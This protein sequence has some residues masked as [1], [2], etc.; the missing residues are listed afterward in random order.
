M[1]DTA[2]L[3]GIEIIIRLCSQIG[4]RARSRPS[5]LIDL[6]GLLS[7]ESLLSVVSVARTY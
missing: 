6:Y 5:K 3:S 2:Y 1:C 7:R 4:S